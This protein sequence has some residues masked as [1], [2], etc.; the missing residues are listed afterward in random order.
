MS[1]NNMIFS[2]YTSIGQFR[3][4]VQTLKLRAQFA[5]KDSNGDPVYNLDA[6][7]P[8]VE[9]TGTIKLH[10]T[11]AGIGFNGDDIWFQSRMGII[12]PLN[13]NA[14][15]ATFYS[16]TEKLE[17]LKELNKHIRNLYVI[18]EDFN[19]IV[20]GEWCGGNIQ[21]TVALNQ[22]S[23]RF[24]IIGL[25]IFQDGNE[26]ESKNLFLT[27]MLFDD[28]ESKHEIYSIRDYEEFV[29]SVDLNNP[30]IAANKIAE[31]TDRVEQE[32][33]FSKKHGVSGI[34]EGIVWTTILNDG[35]HLKFKSKGEKHS[36]VKSKEKS[37]VDVEKLNSISEFVEYAVPT[38]RL[39][40]GIEQVFT[41][42]NI[43]PTVKHTGD[44]IK[45]VI[46][47]VA[48]EELDTL[49]ENGLTIK[50]A[51]GEISKVSRE[52]YFEYLDRLIL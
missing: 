38:T 20:Y 21:K 34:G 52:F 2:E 5:G 43:I 22:L 4:A 45:W 24:V 16:T 15:F 33:P 12:T 7:L 44:F 30:Q 28:F 13:D 14:G 23:K 29:V 11:N 27:R 48:K 46:A 3:N 51:S 36:V 10:G 9:F 17:Y 1:I 41:I 6:P 40:Q 32:C 42:N 37:P 35:N 18:P 19:L 8:T 49:V 31:L 50:E 26:E 25:K 39:E 47:D